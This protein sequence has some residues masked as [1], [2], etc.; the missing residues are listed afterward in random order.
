MSRHEYH[1][2]R[3]RWYKR[4]P[5]RPKPKHESAPQI[6]ARYVGY[7][8]VAGIAVGLGSRAYDRHNARAEALAALPPGFQFSG[9]DEVRARGLA[10]LSRDE[11]GYSS[12][13]DGD[14]DGEACEPIP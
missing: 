12:M 3:G 10:P 11:P 8:L 5:H 1:Y 13:M 2:H 4:K 6:V 9:C 14:N 7:A